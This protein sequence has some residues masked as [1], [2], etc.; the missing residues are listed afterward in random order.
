MFRKIIG[1]ANL[2][3]I[4]RRVNSAVMRLLAMNATFF[5]ITRVSHH[6]DGLLQG[7]RSGCSAT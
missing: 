2:T 1:A 6:A 7:L 3:E 5:L 4:A